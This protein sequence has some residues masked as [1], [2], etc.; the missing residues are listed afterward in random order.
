MVKITVEKFA[1]M[2]V[3]PGESERPDGLPDS[4]RWGLSLTKVMR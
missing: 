1:K 4:P 2:Y 3:V